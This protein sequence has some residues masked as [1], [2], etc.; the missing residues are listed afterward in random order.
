M[1]WLMYIAMISCLLACRHTQTET[2]DAPQDNYSSDEVPASN[3]KH[4]EYLYKELILPN[5][6]EAGIIH[7]YSNYPDY[8]YDIEPRE[9]FTCVDDV[10]RAVIL[11]SGEEQFSEML[12]PMIE[13]LLYMQNDN[14]WFN[15]FIWKD[16]TINTTYKT[17]IAEPNWWS[18]RALWALEKALPKV[19]NQYPEMATRMSEAIDAL[20][21]N[22]V[23]YLSGLKQV[24]KQVNGISIATNLPFESAADQASVLLI[25]LCQNFMRTGDTGIEKSMR[26][27]ADGILKMQIIDGITEGMFLSWEN[28]WHAYGNTQSYALLLTG[29][30]L[31]E[32]AYTSAA[33]KEINAFYPYLYKRGFLELMTVHSEGERTA[34]TEEKVFPQIAYGIRPIVYACVEAYQQSGDK[35][36]KEYALQWLSWFSGKNIASTKMYDHESG[37]CYDGIKSK[38]EI[39][40]NSGAESTIEALLSLQSINTIN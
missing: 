33:M 23:D 11:L 34:I 26:Q 16:L 31:Q 30:L 37:R 36:Y 19:D 29:K 8:S 38:N 1:K 22:T 17:S 7:I 20:L 12:L 14:G 5:G 21:E 40:Q 28:V 6:K 10:A 3:F 32:D 39:N 9:G 35:K 27:L 24:E 25:G 2:G 13:F 18:W 15:N 4:L